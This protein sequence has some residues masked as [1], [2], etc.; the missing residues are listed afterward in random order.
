M[1]VALSEKCHLTDETR[2]KFRV[3]FWKNL[4]NVVE[5]LNS[6]FLDGVCIENTSAIVGLEKL[7]RELETHPELVPHCLLKHCLTKLRDFVIR[8]LNADIS[9]QDIVVL[10]Q[11][12]NELWIS[13][14]H[15]NEHYSWDAEIVR[16]A[17]QTCIDFAKTL[18]QFTANIVPY[19]TPKPLKE[20]MKETIINIL[21]TSPRSAAISA[22]KGVEKGKPMTFYKEKKVHIYLRQC[23][24]TFL[25]G[26][27]ANQKCKVNRFN[28]NNTQCTFSDGRHHC[29]SIGVPLTW[30]I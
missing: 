3:C 18:Y 13:L 23:E 4:P 1:A 25:G 27:Y 20:H 21:E 8:G 15:L 2:E 19:A 26:Q 30:D 14:F 5:V 22:L 12:A 7:I 17:Y 9:F 11:T 6:I 16:D 28:H 10:Y 24:I 29:I